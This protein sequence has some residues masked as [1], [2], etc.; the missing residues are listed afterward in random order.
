M[1]AS[2][3]GAWLG[4][5]TVC[6]ASLWVQ[7][8]IARDEQPAD[9]AEPPRRAAP[10]PRLT[11][12]LSPRPP[13]PKAPSTSPPPASRP[14]ASPPATSPPRSSSPTPAD[15]APPAPTTLQGAPPVLLPYRDLDPPPGYVE[16]HRFNGALLGGG[17]LVLGLT[18]GASI[19]YGGA[20][21]FENGLGGLAVPVIGPWIAIGGR[22]FTCDV[23]TSLNGL[24]VST[25]ETQECVAA[26]TQTAAFLVGLGI[27]QFIGAS[28]L[29]VGLL[30]RRRSW[31]RADLAG[32][33]MEFDVS[34]WPGASGISA[35]GTF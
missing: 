12:R 16:K 11:P 13:S 22:D 17:G 23:D 25:K 19:I 18:Y 8:A 28:L 27:G 34:P 21:K 35:R 3:L 29:T 1:R 30:D 20:H 14:P 4:A 31:L 2:Y 6:S 32:V 5:V 10:V 24:D 26:Q 15:G 33:Q 7:P 9:E